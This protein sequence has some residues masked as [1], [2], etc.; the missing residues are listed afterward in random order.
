[1]FLVS[2]KYLTYNYLETTFLKD[3]LKVSCKV[4]YRYF[5]DVSKVNVLKV[6]KKLILNIKKALKLKIVKA[7]KWFF[8][9][10]LV[11]AAIA[12]LFIP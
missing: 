1:M 2:S 10:N 12:L 5:Q 4:F 7:L 6:L 9:G 11:A 3:F 8:E